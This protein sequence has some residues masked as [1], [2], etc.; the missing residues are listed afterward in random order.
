[1]VNLSRT[2]GHS[3]S[4]GSEVRGVLGNPSPIAVAFP[5][6]LNGWTA[7]PVTRL[8]ALSN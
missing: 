6:P 5:F 4:E 3:V 1:M 2:A 7:L 8:G